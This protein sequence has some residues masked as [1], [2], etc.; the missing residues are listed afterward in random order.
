MAAYNITRHDLLVPV[1][2]WET[3]IWNR[4]LILKTKHAYFLANYT[5]LKA[6]VQLTHIDR[7]DYF[8]AL[9][10][11]V[12]TIQMRII[13][14][15]SDLF[16]LNLVVTLWTS[17][18]QFSTHITKD[19][20]KFP[21]DKMSRVRP[22]KNAFHKNMTPFEQNISKGSI[23]IQKKL[24]WEKVKRVYQS[25][26]ELCDLSN[27]ALGFYITLYT[28]CS[29]LFLSIS[30]DD[31][32]TAKSVDEGVVLLSFIPSFFCVYYFSAS[33]CSNVSAKGKSNI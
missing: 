26:K 3:T 25:I 4:K 12:T 21:I 20:A 11:A 22:V 31:L 15:F 19:I 29:V 9:L 24:Q 18:K 1:P 33:T 23:Q 2:S 7:T 27:Q 32:F 14:Y 6:T 13:A 30:L 16:I 28:A 5:E 8:L 10:A 17:T